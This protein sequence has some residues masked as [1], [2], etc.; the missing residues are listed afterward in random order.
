[1]K[2]IRL[3]ISIAALLL[4]ANCCKDG[5]DLP[6]SD[7][8]SSLTFTISS[9]EIGIDDSSTKTSIG[10]DGKFYWATRDTVGIYPDSG[11][12]VYFV[13]TEGEGASSAQFDGGGW[14]FKAS[15]TYYSYY[16]FVGDI[17]LDRHHIPVSYLGQKQ[18]GTTLLDHIGPFDFMVTPGSS[19]ESGNVHFTYN[20]LNCMIRFRLVLP[21]GTYT[22]LAITAP[23]E[24]FAVKGYYDLMA[25]NPEI[26]AT[27]YSNHLS[28]DLEEITLTEQEEFFVYMMSAP[29]DLKGVEVTVSVLNGQKQ[30]LQCKKTP[31]QPY[32]AGTIYGLGCST[33]TVVP[34]SVSW[35]IAD[36][37]ISNSFSGEV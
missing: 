9:F 33:W 36:W 6:I 26:I 19:S 32:A 28:M 13:L 35:G 4:F 23:S 27:E 17:Y 29:I 24:V 31:S 12:Q 18:V 37:N 34:Q 15:S 14:S 3:L 22:K 5:D 20:H 11:S 2:Q 10:T 30:E 7:E 1:M 25:N 8:V 16:P 21:A